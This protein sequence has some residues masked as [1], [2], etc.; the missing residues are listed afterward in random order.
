M[1]G[2]RRG[3]RRIK[4]PIRSPREV[5]VGRVAH[6]SPVL[7]WSGAVLPLDKVFPPLVRV[8]VP[9]IHSISTVPRR[10]LRSGENC[11]TPIPPDVRTTQPSPASTP[12]SQKRARWGPRIAMNIAQLFHKLRVISNVEIVVPLLPEML[13]IANQTPRYSLLQRL[14]RIRQRILLWFAEQEG[15]PIQAGFWLEWGS[16][17][18]GRIPLLWFA[19]QEVNMLRHDYVPVNLESETAPHPLQG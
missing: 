3:L 6:S 15:W 18:A 7:A 4:H 8:F 13:R 16:S 10:R 17:I 14:Q 2:R 19:E 9:S 12:A 5:R 11:S 1:Q